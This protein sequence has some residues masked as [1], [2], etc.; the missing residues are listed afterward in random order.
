VSTERYVALGLARTRTAWFTEVA[1]WS[2]SA[3]LPLEFVKCLS[4]EEARARL[5]AGR[6]FSALIAD[7]RLAGVDRDLLDLAAAH[8]CAVLVVDDP[9]VARDWAGLGA[10]TTLPEDFTRD[11]L[12]TALDQ[13]ASPVSDPR[14]STRADGPVVRGGWRGS[15]VAVTGI[16]GVGTSTI[17]MAAAQGLA[18]DPRNRDAVVLADLA[19]D[20]DLAVLHDTGEVVPGL[21]ELVDAHRGGEP[22][23]A[24]VERLTFAMPDRGYRLLLGLRRHR[25]W[26]AIRPSA[27]RAALETLARSARLVVADVDPDVEGERACGSID[28]EERN[29]IARTALGTADVVVVVTRPDAVGTYRLVRTIEALVDEGL[30]AARILPL[31]NRAPRSLRARAELTQAFARLAPHAIAD[32]GIANPTYVAERKHLHRAIHDAVPLPDALCRSV[33]AAIGAQLVHVG[34][35]LD[36]TSAI[37]PEPVAV[38]SIG[39]FHEELGS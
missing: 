38:G 28:V 32:G 31:V 22:S 17:A 19:L 36:E 20:A 16:G 5:T 14:A 33:A 4:V 30:S 8:G 23:L 2:T 12:R 1:R 11:D 24:E 34:P 27:L 25:D 13:H 29:V 6:R 10:A 9:R 21:P 35:R 18:R 37:D 3:A 7:G 15:V 26:A 39:H